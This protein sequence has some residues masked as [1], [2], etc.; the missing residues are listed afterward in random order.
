MN[1]ELIDASNKIL[2]DEEQEDAALRAQYGGKFTRL[3]SAS[4]NGQYKQQLI[5]YREKL[6]MAAT[7]DG[8]IKAKFEQNKAGFDLLSLSKGDLSQR[9]PKSH[10][11]EAIAQN[12]AAQAL[13]D[14]MQQLEMIR[15]QK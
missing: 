15:I 12:P 14:L 1:S 3:P 11:S 2:N 7:T 13:R 5:Q 6:N 8:Q 10:S 4:L 9:I